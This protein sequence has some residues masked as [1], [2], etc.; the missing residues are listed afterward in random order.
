MGC[1]YAAIS[2]SRNGRADV[3]GRY[4]QERVFINE[5]PDP[6]PKPRQDKASAPVDRR[7]R[8][9]GLRR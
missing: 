2:A 8:S 6:E 4:S 3:T 9:K 5:D 1:T 7:R